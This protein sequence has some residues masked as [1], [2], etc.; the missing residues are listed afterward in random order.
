MATESLTVRPHHFTGSMRC[1]YRPVHGPVGPSPLLT[2]R[3][4]SYKLS[5]LYS[6]GKKQYRKFIPVIL[7]LDVKKPTL[8][9]KIK[10]APGRLGAGQ[11]ANIARE[12]ILISFHEYRP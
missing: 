12:G 6:A 8:P 9:L 1:R 7:S 11:C 10:Y 2:V 3:M 4:A 5:N